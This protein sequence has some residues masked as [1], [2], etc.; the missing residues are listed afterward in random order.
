[1]ET[2][3]FRFSCTVCGK[4]FS[5]VIISTF[6][7][8][9]LEFSCCVHW[10]GRKSSGTHA[11]SHWRET[12]SVPNMFQT[13]HHLIS[14][15][16]AHEG[17]WFNSSNPFTCQWGDWW[18][19]RHTGE[20]PWKCEYCGKDFLHKDSWKCHLRRHRGEKPFSCPLCPRTFTEQWALKKHY[21]LHTGEK[22]YQVFDPLS[23]WSAYGTIK[24]DICWFVFSATC[25]PRRFPTCRTCR[26][27]ARPTKTFRRPSTRTTAAWIRWQRTDSTSF[28][29]PHRTASSLSCSSARWP[30]LRILPVIW[31]PIPTCSWWTM[32]N[33]T[34]FR[35]RNRKKRFWWIRIT[36]RWWLEH[37]TAMTTCWPS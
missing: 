14:A 1:M 7:F 33:W 34:S 36:T 31:C 19:Q 25:A 15:S 28:T 9:E 32:S 23:L 20:R 22:P 5:Q 18:I 6:Q 35:N 30:D 11:D 26:S 3:L 37:R 10:T 16:S 13:L 4:T 17:N 2:V 12:L 29:S 24:T 27:I 8:L 21:R